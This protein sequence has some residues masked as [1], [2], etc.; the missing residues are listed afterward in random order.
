MSDTITYDEPGV[1][2]DDS[3]Y[4]Y[5]GRNICQPTPV[6]PSR[7]GYW[8]GR[9]SKDEEER[10]RKQRKFLAVSVQ[11][12]C[13]SV[14]GYNVDLAVCDVRFA[15][16]EDDTQVSGQPIGGTAPTVST[17]NVES[18]PLVTHPVD[19]LVASEALD[20]D[21]FEEPEAELSVTGGFQDEDPVWVEA[22]VLT[23]SSQDITL[24]CLPE[25]KSLDTA[26]ITVRA[27]TDE[28][29]RDDQDPEDEG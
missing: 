1:T 28:Y 13:L 6:A 5:D 16:E 22:M 18:S 24:F 2:Y 29:E 17:L 7:P 25:T 14:N 27:V 10:R 11:A 9:R 3:C 23:G 8:V 15:G 21:F 26:I 19:P 12:K 20:G 4:L